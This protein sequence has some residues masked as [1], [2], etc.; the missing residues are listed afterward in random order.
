MEA[1]TNHPAASS[2]ALPTSREM[3]PEEYDYAEQPDVKTFLSWHA[4]G[5]PFRKRSYEFFLNSAL[6]AV[7]IEIMIYI[8]FKDF[9]FMTMVL[10][11]LFLS[12]VLALIPPR[13]FY[14]KITSEG[15]RIED[16][17]FIWDEL[18]DFYF[19]KKHGQDVLHIR[20]KAFFPGELTLTLDDIPVKQVKMTL[21]PFLPFR[22]YVKPSFIDRAGEWMET[23]FPLEKSIR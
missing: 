18:Y 4:P 16:H 11:L 23:N 15:L 8:I 13:P 20:T 6:I 1:H 10:S 3:E 12:F 9:L 14:Y 2:H 7:A 5:R 19:L 17:F 21:L 22:E